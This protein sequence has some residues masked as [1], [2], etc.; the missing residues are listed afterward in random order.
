MQLYLH[1]PNMPSWRGALL[2]HR[3]NFTFFIYTRK[4]QK[5]TLIFFY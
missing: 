2:K 5:V 1:S 3:G 4:S